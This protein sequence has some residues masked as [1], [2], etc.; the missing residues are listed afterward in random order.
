[1]KRQCKFITST[2]YLY[3]LL[4][5]LIFLIGWVKSIIAVPIIVIL[6]FCYWKVCNNSVAIW[7]PGFNAENL[8]KIV[9]VLGT[10]ALWVYMSGIGKFVY[11]NNDHSV[12]NTVFNILV[13]YD[14][15]V[16]NTDILPEN[17]GVFDTTVLIYYIGYW[18]PSALVGKVFGLRAGYYAQ[19]VWAVLG[20]ALVYY[21]ICVKAKKIVI[22]PLWIFIFFSGLDIV[23]VFLTNADITSYESIWHAEWWSIPYEYSSM[24]TQL[25]WVFNQ[26][27]PAWICTMLVYVQQNNRNLVFILACCMLSSTFPFVGLLLIVVFLCFSRKY[28]ELEK[29][30]ISK[31]TVKVKEYFKCVIKDTCTVQNVIG[32]GI[33]G[34]IS[35]LYLFGNSSGGRILQE[36]PRGPAYYNSLPKLVL[37]LIL[38]VL[39]FAVLLYK[40]NKNNKLFYFVILLLCI[41]P[42][43]KVG[44]SNDFCMRVSIPFLF[45][46]MLWIIE[47]VARAWKEKDYGLFAGLVIVLII[48]SA[49]PVLELKRTWTYTYERINTDQI[50]YAEDKDAVDILNSGNFS[51]DIEGNFFFEYIAK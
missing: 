6:L 17:R 49:T 50:V 2:A 22:W 24:T 28:S 9:F 20:I 14:W 44:Y 4:P 37:F 31:K 25:F 48:G 19:A 16:K 29:F 34:I 39:V 11:Q 43:I 8:I 26:A 27:I 5:F 32:G 42:P 40:Y 12:R 23:G 51:G 41:I 13:E 30:R 7:I 45:I 10:I 3:I 38:E 15:P 33:I 47:A 46:I 18:L 36:D 21:F 1:M 35:F